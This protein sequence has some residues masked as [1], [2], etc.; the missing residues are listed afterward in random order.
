MSAPYDVI[1]LGAGPAGCA[2]AVELVRG[3]ARV[4]LLGGRPRSKP[5]GG[6]LSLRWQGELARLD[7]PGWLWRHR[8]RTLWLTAPGREPVRWVSGAAGAVLVERRRL[9]AWLAERAAAEGARLLPLRARALEAGAGGVTVRAEGELLRARWLIGADG[10]AGLS[11]RAL[12]L[13]QTRRGFAALVEERPLPPGLAARLR[14]AAVLELGGVPGGYAWLFPRGGVANLG[15]GT[16]LG[17]RL[18]ARALVAALNRFLARCGLGPARAWRGALIPWTGSRPPRGRGRVLL[19]GDAAELGDPFLGEGIGQALHSG[20]LAARAVLAGRPGQYRDEL[21]AG[22][23]REHRHARMLA[24][25]V[26]GGGGRTQ[27]LARRRPGALELGFG[28]LRGELSHAGLWGEVAR[29][30]RPRQTR[31]TPP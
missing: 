17:N 29:R 3:G 8:V 6:C 24:W 25:M 10:A 22:L 15:V 1:V 27:A 23:L 12:G 30:L 18:G 16:S 21:A 5:C 13:G 31:L 4:L 11:R 9:D 26:Y 7:P 20:R 19:A 14:G 2:A 28:L